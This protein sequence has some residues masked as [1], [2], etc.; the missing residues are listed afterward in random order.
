MKMKKIN[1]RSVGAATCRFALLPT[2][3][4]LTVAAGCAPKTTPAL[5][6]ARAAYQRASTNE[7]VTKNAPVSLYE[8]QIALD[9]AEKT[10]K[11]GDRKD[12]D[13][14]AY[15]AKRRAEIAEQLAVENAAQKELTD[16]GAQRTK[17][18]L[19]AR[20]AELA[21]LKA[22]KTDRGVL[23]TFEDV[24]FEFGKADLKP[25]TVR[26]L[27]RLVAL[28]QE[29]P[30]RNLLIEGH[31]DSVGSESFNLDLSRRR[32]EAVANAL[33]NAGVSRARITTKGLGKGY[34][35]ASNET[36]SGRQQNRRAELYILPEGQ[37]GEGAARR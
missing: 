10:L 14:L 27:D 23:I 1:D 3:L 36:A 22:K 33:V 30:E 8:A 9:N 2:A 29:Y 24:L 21:A 19:E 20:D 15:V 28:L 11:K 12:A 25:A 18:L 31:T 37:T 32:A 16:L 26:S 17:T 7:N 13:T 34:P 6:E 4:L 35:V 5:D